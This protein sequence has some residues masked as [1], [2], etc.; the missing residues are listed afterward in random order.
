MA[1]CFFAANARL[2]LLETLVRNGKASV[3][4]P[5]IASKIKNPAF[6]FTS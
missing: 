3:K 6:A 1:Y 2:Y 4:T 5:G